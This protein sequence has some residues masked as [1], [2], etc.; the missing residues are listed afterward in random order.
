MKYNFDELVDRRGTDAI[1]WDMLGSHFGNPDALPMWVADMDFLTAPAIQEALQTR[2]RHGIFGY[3]GRPAGY[4]EVIRRWLYG[5]HGWQPEGEWLVHA[6]GVVQGIA[7]AIAAYTDPGDEILVFPPVYHP[8]FGVTEGQRRRIVESPLVFDGTTYRMDLDNLRTVLAEH[9]PKLAIL[10]NPHNPVGRVWTEEELRPAAELLLEAGVYV[11]SDEIHS[12][13]V[14]PEYQHVPY[15]SL[16]PDFAAS[17]ATLYAPSK[18]FG[19]A[20][21]RSSVVVIPDEARR[22]QYTAVQ[23]AFGAGHMSAFGMAALMAGYGHGAEWL[24]QLLAY[25]GGTRDMVMKT[26]SEEIPRIR[27]IR[28]EGT[29]MIWLDCRGLELDDQGLAHFMYQEAAVAL[30]DGA[31]FGTGGSGFMRMNMAMPRSLVAE[32]LDRIKNAVGARAHA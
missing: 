13:L 26:F 18:T 24:D 17:S 12:D 16:G 5:R 9:K 23:G 22:A 2:A 27:A 30:N 32:G 29:Y 7:I 4:E 21:L 31:G 6:N 11:L 3:T 8:F 10:C 25:I 14:Y 20:G 1:K 19:I 28:P 15:P